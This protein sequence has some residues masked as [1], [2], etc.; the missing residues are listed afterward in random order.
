MSVGM[1]RADL[2]SRVRFFIDEPQQQNFTDADINAALNVAQLQVQLEMN[3]ANEDY[4]VS[5]VPTP[6]TLQSGTDTYPLAED[7]L[8]IVRV[9]DANTGLPIL[10]VDINE[11]MPTGTLNSFPTLAGAVSMNWYLVGDSIGFTPPPTGTSLVNYWYVPVVPD[12]ASDTAVPQIPAPYRD[13]IA[14]RAAID[15]FI[16]DEADITNLNAL[17][18]EYLSRLKRT[19]KSRNLMAPKHVR[20]TSR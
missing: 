5:P 7:C 15:S 2:R 12:M 19:I 6:I 17:W 11:K 9:E 16:K 4:F 3:Q 20:R 10:P 13:M 8:N 14:V 1:T 18:M